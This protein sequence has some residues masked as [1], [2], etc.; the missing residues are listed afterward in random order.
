MVVPDPLTVFERF[1]SNRRPV[2]DR[3]GESDPAETARLRREPSKRPAKVRLGFEERMLLCACVAAVAAG[4][5]FL[6]WYSRGSPAR[7]S[8]R[9]PA[10]ERV[11][12][13]SAEDLRRA[14]EP[15]AV[16]YGLRAGVFA[17]EKRARARASSF[18]ARGLNSRVLEGDDGFTVVVG[19]FVDPSEAKLSP[20]SREIRSSGP[21]RLP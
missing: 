21:V 8:A 13:W 1:E 7:P 14:L 15:A 6:G 16:R 4:S 18:A 5:F 12:T 3:T 9:E 20:L 11:E 17:T 2:P 19:E 10:G